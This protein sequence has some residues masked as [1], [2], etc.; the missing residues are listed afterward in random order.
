MKKMILVSMLALSACA[1]QQPWEAQ[2][3]LASQLSRL[4]NQGAS[5]ADVKPQPAISQIDQ[6]EIT[7]AT[8]PTPVGHVSLAPKVPIQSIAKGIDLV[9]GAIVC[10]SMDEAN[11]LFGQINMARHARLSLPADLRRRAA[12]VNGYDIGEEPNPS[13]YRC[14]FVP[15]GTPMNVKMEGGYLPVVWGTMKDG[16]PF[17][18]GT[19]P[20]MIER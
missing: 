8:A 5:D 10:P 4:S 1:T 14:Q 13:D 6:P 7:I 3:P 9:D 2:L 11:W 19:N 20:Q 17:A 18:G 16:R 15:A 12:L